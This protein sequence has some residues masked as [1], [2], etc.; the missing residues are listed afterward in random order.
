MVFQWFNS[1]AFIGLAPEM[2]RSFIFLQ[3]WLKQKI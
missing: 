1:P 3:N 2:E